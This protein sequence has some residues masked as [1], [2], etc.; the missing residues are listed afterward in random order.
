MTRMSSKTETEQKVPDWAL[1]LVAE[2]S[3]DEQVD[4]PG[5]QESNRMRSRAVGDAVREAVRSGAT[6]EES[7]R[8][9]VEKRVKRRVL[10]DEELDRVEALRR[11][12]DEMTDEEKRLLLRRLTPTNGSA[13]ARS[14]IEKEQGERAA[15]LQGIKAPR[16]NDELWLLIKELTGYEIPRVAVCDDHQA[17]FDWV[18]DAYFHR[19][20]A[21]LVLAS[22]EQGKSLNASI[23]Q[24]VSAETLSGFEGVIFAA[25]QPQA[26][27]VYRYIRS[28]VYQ[29]DQEGN[30]IPKPQILGDPTRERTE[31]RSGSSV[32]CIVGSLSGVNSPHPNTVHADEIDLMDMEIFEESRAMSSSSTVDGVRIPALDLA[33]STRKSSRGPMQKL[34]DEVEEAV[35]HGHR[36]A[37]ALYSSCFREVASEVPCCRRADPIERVHRLV[38]LG[39]DPRELCRCDTIVKGIWG[40]RKDENGIE[41]PIPRTLE[42]VCRGDLFKSRG[43]FEYEDVVGKFQQMSK[44]KWEA[45]MECR[46]PMADGLYLPNFSRE[47]HCIRGWVPRPEH[48]YLWEGVDWGGTAPSVVVFIQGP[49]F[50]PVQIVG[51]EGE[52]FV[53]PQ[54][55]L[56]I[57]DMIEQAGIG[58]SKLADLVCVKEATYRQRFPGWRVKGRFTDMAGKQQRDDWHQHSPPLRTHWYIA[59]DFDPTVEALQDLVADSRLYVDVSNCASVADDFEAWRMKN[60]R[61]VKDESTHTPAAS[62]YGAA[63]ILAINRRDGR[64][65]QKAKILPVV[66]ER[67]QDIALPMA[68]ESSS[69]IDFA[70]RPSTSGGPMETSGITSEAWRRSFQPASTGELDSHGADGWRIG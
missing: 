8:K 20:R 54:G 11:R 34:I 41:Q 64:K 37:W 56:V 47:L 43:W 51:Y 63:N 1:R 9:L 5:D 31:W 70:G 58:A 27:Q 62:R 38:Q 57:F 15:K 48:G 14:D 17:P 33:T 21:I 30:R 50:H 46:R 60:G 39:R 53:V 69:A 4:N 36:P 35:R 40:T 22:R 65:D 13:T 23:I 32:S 2:R 42:T 12:T 26:K 18:A 28:F 24:Y 45:Q 44:A 59:R 68:T 3:F 67:V 55:S 52:A 16:N 19:H 49:T 6:D 7:V 66:R 61:E 25:I 10:S 29:R